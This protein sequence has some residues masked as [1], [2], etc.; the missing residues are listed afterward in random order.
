MSTN[1]KILISACGMAMAAAALGSPSSEVNMRPVETARPLSTDAFDYNMNYPITS[2]TLGDL[3]DEPVAG[4]APVY[5]PSD[6]GSLRSRRIHMN[7]AVLDRLDPIAGG[8]VRFNLFEDLAYEA[9]FERVET[10]AVGQSVWYGRLAGIPF[11]DFILVREGDVVYATIRDYENRR[12]VQ[13]RQRS[14]AGISVVREMGGGPAA[15]CGNTSGREPAPLDSEQGG[16]AGSGWYCGYAN[17]NCDSTFVQDQGP[18]TDAGY[19]IDLLVVWTP[20]ARAEEGGT[21]EIRSLAVEAY[22]D[23]N[24]RLSNSL[25]TPRVRLVWLEEMTGYTENETDELHRLFCP[26]DGYMDTVHTLRETHQADL[27]HL[28]VRDIDDDCGVG[29]VTAGIAYRPS[30]FA[31]SCNSHLYWVSISDNNYSTGTLAHEVGHNLGCC[32]DHSNGCDNPIVPYAFGKCFY[33]FPAYRH[34]TMS[35]DCSGGFGDDIPYYSNPDIEVAGEPTGTANDEDNARTI[36]DTR[37]MIANYRR[38][39][40]TRYSGPWLPV[41]VGNG[42]QL[43]PYSSINLGVLGVATGGTVRISGGTYPEGPITWTKSVTLESRGGVV[44]IGG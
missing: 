12:C 8:R 44:T 26:T 5:D 11:A 43:L 15:R 20:Q 25:T 4:L 34:T 39:D 37:V 33:A 22:A 30:S 42:S 40:H 41:N 14:A 17:D 28:I 1:K 13:I 19:A 23:M 21:S 2:R 16:A 36:D 3:L 24:T 29:C 38:G 32:H 27:V 10:L 9:V 35:Y 7:L 31:E 18:D 6:A